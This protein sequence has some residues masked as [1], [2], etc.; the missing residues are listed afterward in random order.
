MTKRILALILA[1][2]LT[3]SAVSALAAEYTDAETVRMVQQALNDAGY[4]CGKPDGI[5]GHKTRSAIM[6]YQKDKGLEQTGVVDDALLVALG[7]GE[8]TE[9]T[10]VPNDTAEAPA[11]GG[12]DLSAVEAVPELYTI[13][14]DEAEDCAFI[15]SQLSAQ[16]RSFTHKYESSNRWSNTKFDV[17]V[18]DRSQASAYPLMRLW[19]VY[20]ADD[21]YLDFDSATFVINGTSYTFT[22]LIENK[23]QDENGYVERRLIK[24]GLDNLAFPADLEEMFADAEDIQQ[25]IDNT[26]CKL[27]LH[28]RE[29]DIEADL[30]EGFLFDFLAIKMAYVDLGGLNDEY[31]NKLDATPLQ[32]E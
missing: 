10:L 6:A 3:L 31:L 4:D 20:C 1:A 16:T 19:I 30:G 28:G 15:E 18:V 25:V 11:G 2:V 7:I 9:S 22:N 23:E 8:A 27:I 14:Y 17:L 24:F 13:D 32:V 29:E 21:A 12:F 5:A 26:T